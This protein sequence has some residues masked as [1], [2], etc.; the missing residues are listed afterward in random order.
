MRTVPATLPLLT[1]L[2]DRTTLFQGLSTPDRE[3][4]LNRVVMLAATP[5]DVLFRQGTDARSTYLVLD[6]QVEVRRADSAGHEQVLHVFGTGQLVGEV[7]MFRGGCYPA[8]AVCV[9][10]ARLIR[11]DRTALQDSLHR[12]PELA[13]ALLAAVCE[14]L[15]TFVDLVESL[16]LKDGSGRL[17]SALLQL[18]DAAGGPQVRLPSTKAALAAHLGMAPETLSRRLRSFQD[19]GLIRVRGRT[20]ELLQPDR[21]RILA[22]S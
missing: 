20:I 9:A 5:G 4:L 17:A 10:E 7:P 22:G 16:A 13:L 3:R 8:S 14:R 19:Q 18:A 21:L 11:I 12:S 6:G 1:R 2:T 15:R